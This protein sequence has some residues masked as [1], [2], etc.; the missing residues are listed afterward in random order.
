MRPTTTITIVLLM[1][2]VFATRDSAAQEANDRPS[3]SRTFVSISSIFQRDRSATA[4]SI[5]GLTRKDWNTIR[6]THPDAIALRAYDEQARYRGKTQASVIVGCTPRMAKV[7]N[8]SLRNGRFITEL[9]IKTS[10]NV[11]VINTELARRLFNNTNPIGRNV[12]LPQGYFLVVGV[13]AQSKNLTCSTHRNSIKKTPA[14]LP[15]MYMPLSAMKAR[16]GDTLIK[17]DAGAFEL[18]RFELSEIITSGTVDELRSLIRRS[19]E[20][21]DKMSDLRFSTIR[22]PN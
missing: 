20:P 21:D 4:P 9:D 10:E 18:H 11:C 7:G 19:R 14:S 3:D 12:K 15:A 17:R 1:A 22:F 6:Q 5:Y 2:S 8:L 13:C 16:I